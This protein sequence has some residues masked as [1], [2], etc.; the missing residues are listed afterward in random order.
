VSYKELAIHRIIKVMDR[1]D[2]GYD[3]PADL[4]ADLIHYCDSQQGVDRGS[5]SFEEELRVAY[6][7]VDDELGLDAELADSEDR[8]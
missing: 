3:R 4:L 7:Y 8:E 1:E 2:N 5:E 6:S